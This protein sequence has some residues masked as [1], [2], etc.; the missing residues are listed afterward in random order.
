MLSTLNA[1]E[2]AAF[3]KSLKQ[4]HGNEDIIL[5]A[6]D[7]IRKLYPD[8]QDEKK[9]DQIHAYGKIFRTELPHDLEDRKK[10]LKNLFN[11]LYDLHGR[12]KNFLLLEKLRRD[13]LESQPLW[14]SILKERG[15][16]DEYN[17]QVTRF[18]ADAKAASPKNTNGYLLEMMAAHLHFENHSI[19]TPLP[20]FQTLQQCVTTL[21]SR[22]DIIRLKMNCAVANLKK[23]RP[24]KPVTDPNISPPPEMQAELQDP[25]LEL[26]RDIYELV[27]L[28]QEA[29]YD[30]IEQMLTAYAHQLDAEEVEEVIS[31]LRNF[32]AVQNR[33]GHAD[34]YLPKS[35]QLNK[36]AFQYGVPGQPVPATRFCNVVNSGCSKKDFDW[37]NSFI[38][39][40]A[41][42][43]PADIRADTITLCKAIICFCQDDFAG[44]LQ[45]ANALDFRDIHFIIRTNLLLLVSQVELKEDAYLVLDHCD[46][47]EGQL[48]RHRKPVTGAVESALAFVR[49]L[50]ML[51]QRKVERQEL[52][53][54][55]EKAP[56][57][58]LRE[59][60]K[61]KAANYKSR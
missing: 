15:M 40:Q 17:K 50:R 54:R 47:F 33:K 39:Q 26:Y 7:Y 8:F 11:T 18:Y 3:H 25:L 52:I 48:L 20:D 2:L 6:F 5:H 51:L 14:L 45:Y 10:A 61:E 29:C 53:N 55:I 16:K 59:W 35:H 32:G 36:L 23:V 57:L 44:V 19:V 56:E 27:T 9:L 49:L 30:R 38:I 28:E 43:L 12:L 41:P 42:F 31:Y 34:I 13:E 4:L 46:K 1:K 22:A 60:L 21:G 24:V 58:N 37:V